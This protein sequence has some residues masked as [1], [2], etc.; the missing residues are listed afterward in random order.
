MNKAL[1]AVV[2]LLSFV[3]AATAQEKQAAKPGTMPPQLEARE[4]MLWEA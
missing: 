4:R 1:V 3:G 2:L